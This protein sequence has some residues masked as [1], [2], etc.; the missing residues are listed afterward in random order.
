[1]P[2]SHKGGIVARR[3][4]TQYFDDLDQTPL[5]ESEVNIVHFSFNNK[6]YLL[7]LSDAN[8][9]RFNETLM[10]YIAAAREVPEHDRM[11]EASAVRSWARK[12]GL[13][14]A[15][16]GKIPAAIVD[17]YRKAHA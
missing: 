13:K 15:Q 16:R 6:D 5:D 17:A 1:M 9:A 3:E 2:N 7:D 10:P 14:I 8:L 11:T 12:Q 4:I